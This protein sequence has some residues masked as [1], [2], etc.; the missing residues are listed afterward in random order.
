[1]RRGFLTLSR[2]RILQ[3]TLAFGCLLA[4]VDG[5]LAQSTGPLDP[6]LS[7]EK[8]LD[9]AVANIKRVYGEPKAA[10]L[11]GGIFQVQGKSPDLDSSYVLD[12]EFWR[13]LLKQH[14]EGLVVAVPNRGGLLFAPATDEKAVDI[15]RSN[16]GQW[17]VQ[18]DR[19]RV[20][21]ALYLFKD[22]HWSVYQ[23]PQAH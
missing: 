23:A 13:V 12:R 3:L 9:L 5:A 4:L 1:M 10:P 20:S 11:T 18:S 14:P 2:R 17:Y 16:V 15:L 21:S 8:A 19:L 6:K 22:D 7:P